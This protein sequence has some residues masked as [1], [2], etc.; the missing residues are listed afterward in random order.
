MQIKILI[1]SIYYKTDNPITKGK[2]INNVFFDTIKAFYKSDRFAA[3]Y[4]N[5]V[6][7]GENRDSSLW[8][9]TRIHSASTL[10][11]L[12]IKMAQKT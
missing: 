10:K 5:G 12:K 7:K 11:F 4:R 2:H 1:K 9:L 8:L 3:T 6:S